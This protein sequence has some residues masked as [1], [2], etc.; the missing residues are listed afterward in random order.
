MKASEIK[1]GE[2]VENGIKFYSKD[3][4]LHPDIGA[5]LETRS[6][7]SEFTGI[8]YTVTKIIHINGVNQTRT[9]FAQVFYVPESVGENLEK[10]IYYIPVGNI[11]GFLEAM[12]T[13]FRNAYALFPNSLNDNVKN[14]N[15]YKTFVDPQNNAFSFMILLPQGCFEIIN[16][17]E[18]AGAKNVKQ[19]TL[20]TSQ[21]I[22]KI[23]RTL[24]DNT[25]ELTP[26]LIKRNAE[27][28]IGVVLESNSNNANPPDPQLIPKLTLTYYQNLQDLNGQVMDYS[29]NPNIQGFI[30]ANM[31]VPVTIIAK[32]INARIYTDVEC[33]KL[34]GELMK[35]YDPLAQQ[36]SNIPSFAAPSANNFA[37]MPT[38][39]EPMRLEENLLLDREMVELDGETKQR[40]ENYLRDDKN[41]TDM[42]SKIIKIRQTLM[43]PIYYFNVSTKTKNKG[44]TILAMV[45]GRVSPDNPF[46]LRLGMSTPD[47][48]SILN[49]P[50]A[51]T[52]KS[53]FVKKPEVIS[54]FQIIGKKIAAE[55]AK[56]KSPDEL[57][58]IDV[59]LEVLM[60]V[61]AS[62]TYQK[63]AEI[64]DEE[65]VL[66]DMSN[67]SRFPVDP[68]L[69]PKSFGGK[70]NSLMPLTPVEAQAQNNTYQYL[71][72]KN[73]DPYP[74]PKPYLPTGP[75]IKEISNFESVD[76]IENWKE[77]DM[78]KVP[79]SSLANKRPPR[80]DVALL[81]RRVAVDSS[82]ASLVETGQGYVNEDED[83]ESI[84]GDD[85]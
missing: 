26:A 66:F 45:L 27:L 53:V 33:P 35:S 71:L 34:V 75:I 14:S 4:L 46:V 10:K 65:D 37:P 81:A 82:E 60:S 12:V 21:H 22:N 28:F 68:S 6:A 39:V 24:P 83:E 78:S 5:F 58:L 76:G 18:E 19:F 57:P 67:Y 9:D 80:R 55:L 62:T 48:R 13:K 29:S 72:Q 77:L 41:S 32:N 36:Q 73:K 52:P 16:A 17:F 7:V 20:I 74:V 25:K 70:K 69:K 63:P 2:V 50:N 44:D 49:V 11:A 47:M 3:F 8:T 59:P 15:W 1:N 23:M 38:N 40:I 61:Q 84:S 85:E 79:N 43:N 64:E 51:S 31:L 30:K 42:A 56:I 54:V